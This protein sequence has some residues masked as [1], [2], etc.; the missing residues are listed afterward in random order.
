M[1]PCSI[2]IRV[3]ERDRKLPFPG[4]QAT[5]PCYVIKPDP[6]GYSKL[7]TMAAMG[8]LAGLSRPK[9][10]KKTPSL[11]VFEHKMSRKQALGIIKVGRPNEQ[12][13]LIS[14]SFKSS[15]YNFAFEIM[16]TKE[17]TRTFLTFNQKMKC[18]RIIK[19]WLFL[20]IV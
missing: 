3:N 5:Y 10:K 18:S 1:I 12:N 16:G 17:Q 9:K 20:A 6:A 14:A 2:D 8:R 4:N 7:I 13:F 15:I 19:I 11:P